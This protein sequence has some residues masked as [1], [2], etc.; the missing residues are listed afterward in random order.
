MPKHAE[1]RWESA[2]NGKRMRIPSDIDPPGTGPIPCGFS[3][4]DP[5]GLGYIRD[6]PLTDRAVTRWC[7]HG[8]GGPLSPSEAAFIAHLHCRH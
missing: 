2:V 4:L 7:I 6:S 8:A 5:N 1:P 3:L